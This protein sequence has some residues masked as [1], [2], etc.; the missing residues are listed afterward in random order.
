LTAGDHPNGD[1]RAPSGL[2][3]RAAGRACHRP[4]WVQGV[5]RAASRLA[6][7][8]PLPGGSGGAAMDRPPLPSAAP[9]GAASLGSSV[10]TVVRVGPRREP[11]VPR[12]GG[13]RCE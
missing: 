6:S 12:A 2:S 4:R 7:R 5:D 3:G 9:R 8:A 1:P 10:S 13:V 11:A